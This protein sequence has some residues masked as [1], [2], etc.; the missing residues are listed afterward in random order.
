MTRPA[1][2][3]APNS[4]VACPVV[5]VDMAAMMAAFDR[6]PPAHRRL[7]RDAPYNFGVAGVERIP[8]GRLRAVLAHVERR[9]VVATYGADH[10]QA[11]AG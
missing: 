2:N 8:L 10:P 5:A 11:R 3:T 7:L 9:S 6:L 1:G 4:G